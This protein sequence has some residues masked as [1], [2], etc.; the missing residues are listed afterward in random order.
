MEFDD[1]VIQTSDPLFSIIVFG[2]VTFRHRY[3]F[4]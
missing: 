4:T 2:V 3:V 1:L